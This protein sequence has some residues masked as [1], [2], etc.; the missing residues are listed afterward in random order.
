MIMT[1][2]VSFELPI[3]ILALAALGIVTPAVPEQVPP[4]RDRVDR[5][6]RGVSHSG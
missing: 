2:G 5:H 3:V 1:F 6:H 4:A